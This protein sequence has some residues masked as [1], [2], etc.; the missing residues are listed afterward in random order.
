MPSLHD[1]DVKKP[2]L[3]LCGG[4]E[5]KPVTFFFFS[6]TSI[7]QTFRIEL[8]KNLPTFDELNDMGYKR[9]KV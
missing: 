8:Q 7:Q 4:R 1:Y 2:N 5:H 9:D 3:T 6:R